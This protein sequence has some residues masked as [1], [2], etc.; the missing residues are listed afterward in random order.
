MSVAASVIVLEGKDFGLPSPRS[1]NP[2]LSLS[3]RGARGGGRWGGR[4]GQFLT[5]MVG[6]S[7]SH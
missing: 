2:A 1:L 7:T 5:H 4:A 6:A 3:S